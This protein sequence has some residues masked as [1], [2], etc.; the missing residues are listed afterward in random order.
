MFRP[1][2]TGRHEYR[3]SFCEK[4][5]DR[6]KRLIAGPRGVY[7]C[8]ECIDLCQQIIHEEEQTLARLENQEQAHAEVRMWQPQTHMG[9][10]S[11]DQG[12]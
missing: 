6:V 5:Q 7:I 10:K 9:R 12:E 4:P 3:C 1:N 8:N 11:G 2:R